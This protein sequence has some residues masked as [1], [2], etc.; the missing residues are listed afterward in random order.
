MIS[1]IFGFRASKKRSSFFLILQSGSGKFAVISS[2]TSLHLLF[3][4]SLYVSKLFIE[5]KYI[6][7]NVGKMSNLKIF[8]KICDTD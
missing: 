2:P 6:N 8:N 5:V 7:K 1:F 4:P 3:L